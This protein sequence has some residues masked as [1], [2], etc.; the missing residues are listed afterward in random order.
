VL[1]DE[2]KVVAG[3]TCFGDASMC[4]IRC[5]HRRWLVSGLADGDDVQRQGEE[6]QGAGASG[7]ALY[8]GAGEGPSVART[9]RG[10]GG[11][12]D[13]V[14]HGLSTQRCDSPMG[15]SG[16]GRC[17]SVQHPKIPSPN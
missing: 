17:G 15:R 12:P 9:P 16:P 2:A 4:R 5:Q 7:G 10:G 3:S 13:S 1:Y 6:E 8:R 11:A 14:V